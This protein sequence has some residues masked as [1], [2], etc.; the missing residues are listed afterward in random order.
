M[1]IYIQSDDCRHID[2]C[3]CIFE[4]RELSCY[5]MQ[6]IRFLITTAGLKKLSIN[7]VSKQS[8]FERLELLLNENL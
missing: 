4:Q 5:S 3:T 1:L 7:V 2:G 8:S 6:V